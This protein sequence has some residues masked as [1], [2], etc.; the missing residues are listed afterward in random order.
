MLRDPDA[1]TIVFESNPHTL[2]QVGSSPN[3]L[4]RALARLGYQLFL[5]EE[6]DSLRRVRP[7]SF[8]PETVTDYLAVKD[9]RVIHPAWKIERE[10][11]EEELVDAVWTEATSWNPDHRRSIAL[12][13][14]SAPPTLLTHPKVARALAIITLDRDSRV[15]HATRWWRD[16]CPPPT[17]AGLRSELE[18]AAL[19]GA[20]LAERASQ[21]RTRPRTR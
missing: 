1:P 18:A 19:D 9:E 12:Q 4:L 21:A 17:L 20:A 6:P 5:I 10:R 11:T 13:L 3:D 2:T 14:R 15:A 7:E 16:R 8:Q